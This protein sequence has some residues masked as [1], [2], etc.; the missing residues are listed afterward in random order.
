MLAAHVFGEGCDLDIL[1]LAEN[2]FHGGLGTS[3]HVFLQHE[4]RE[5]CL[6]LVGALDGYALVEV[7]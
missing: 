4:E 1:V 6:A 7:L 2:A 5:F 3:R